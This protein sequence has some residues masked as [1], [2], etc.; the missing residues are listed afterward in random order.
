MLPPGQRAGPARE[1]K[2]PPL[3]I[4]LYDI[5][6]A[7]RNRDTVPLSTSVGTTALGLSFKY[8]GFY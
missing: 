4:Y 3:P 1:I 5:K 7:G 8:S 2:K 6:A